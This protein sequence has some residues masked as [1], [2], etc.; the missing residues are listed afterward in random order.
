MG[1][2]RVLAFLLTV[3]SLW[4]LAWITTDKRE[5]IYKSANRAECQKWIRYPVSTNGAVSRS[6]SRRV[7]PEESLISISRANC[8]PADKISECCL[9]NSHCSEVPSESPRIRKSLSPYLARVFH[10]VPEGWLKRI[11]SSFSESE[12]W[13]RTT[14]PANRSWACSESFHWNPKAGK[15]RSSS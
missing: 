3:P 12:Y 10:L 7:V 13:K 4:L 1:R 14:G 11:Q 8:Q 5:G 6:L 2:S 15:K 9:V